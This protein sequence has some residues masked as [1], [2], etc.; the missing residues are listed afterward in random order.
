VTSVGFNAAGLGE[1]DAETVVGSAVFVEW[2]EAALAPP[3]A[4]AVELIRPIADE[5][6]GPEHVRA[7]I[8]EVVSGTA[9]GRTSEDEVTLY[10]SVGVA[11]Q[12]AA[13]AAIVLEAARRSGA[14]TE[15]E[16]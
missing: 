4:G 12:D 9:A 15:V 1:V 8:G 13:A 16:I 2:R 6:I 11:A 10:K 5:L 3:P 7:E 14:G